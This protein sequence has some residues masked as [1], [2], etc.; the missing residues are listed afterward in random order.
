MPVTPAKIVNRAIKPT[1]ITALGDFVIT[2]TGNKIPLITVVIIPHVKLNTDSFD[3]F[4]KTLHYA[5]ILVV[6]NIKNHWVSP[7]K[8][9]FV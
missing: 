1:N 8:I 5:Y 2:A 6:V 7:N 9:C 3:L 4:I